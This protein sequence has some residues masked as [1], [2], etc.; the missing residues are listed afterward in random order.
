MLHQE[1]IYH[2]DFDVKDG[3]DED[4]SYL[5]LSEFTFDVKIEVVSSD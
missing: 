4:Y 5:Y 1:L 2:S 3:D